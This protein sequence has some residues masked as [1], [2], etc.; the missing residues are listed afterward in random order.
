MYASEKNKEINEIEDELKGF[1]QYLSKK[2]GGRA[3]IVKVEKPSQKSEPQS[4]LQNK[5][6]K[7]KKIIEGLSALMDVSEGDS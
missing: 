6:E 4:E 3:Q 7:L 2:H 1:M 5:K